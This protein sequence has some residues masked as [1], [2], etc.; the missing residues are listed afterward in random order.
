MPGKTVE[1]DEEDFL[2]SQRLRGVVEKIMSDPKARVLVEQA[3]KLVDANAKTPTLDAQKTT[4]EP[5]VSLEKKIDEFISSQTKAQQERE[6][7]NKRAEL[8]S[9]VETG[10]AKL[11]QDGW[12]DDG[13]KAVEK[14]MEDQGILDPAIAAAYHE[15]LHPPQVPTTPSGGAWNF[16]EIPK[17]GGDAYEKALLD[18]KGQNDIIAE[19]EAMNVLNEIRGARRN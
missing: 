14:I 8:R 3:H 18:S 19:R 16:P 1:V 7:E 12:T 5:V 15:K 10:I 17:D 13:I 9:K 4:T 11:R 6:A 2:R